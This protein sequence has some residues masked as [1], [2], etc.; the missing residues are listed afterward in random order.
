MDV[1]KLLQLQTCLHTHTDMHTDK[2]I[3]IHSLI[4]RSKTQTAH[5]NAYTHFDGWSKLQQA[6]FD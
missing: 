1:P 2:H 4:V 3:K 6:G 5:V